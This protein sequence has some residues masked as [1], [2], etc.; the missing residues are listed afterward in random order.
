MTAS[1][2][3]AKQAFAI[4]TDK[5]QLSALIKSIGTRGRSLDKAIHQAAVSALWH[6]FQHKSTGYAENLLAEMGK[7]SRKNA[8]RAWLLDMGCFMVKEDGKTLGID[9][10]ARAAGFDE[11]RAIDTPFWDYN[12]E[13]EVMTKLDAM[14][15]V[16]K[17]VKRL[18]KAKE[19]GLL[20]AEGLDVLA[21]VAQVA[22]SVV[23]TE[24]TTD[25]AAEATPYDMK[26]A[27]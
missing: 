21:K 20:D 16:R 3:P 8:L 18:T 23:E 19:D 17:L 10:T 9:A 12:K 24:E 25:E 7:S 15:A 5:A 11:A 6:G 22:P 14:E 2:K 26:A 27:A 1:K 4:V 13:P